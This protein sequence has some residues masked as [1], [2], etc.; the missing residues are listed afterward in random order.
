MKPVSIPLYS[1]SSVLRFEGKQSRKAVL[2]S[3]DF[4]D[5]LIRWTEYGKQADELAFKRTRKRLKKLYPQSVIVINTGRALP[6]V[7]SLAHF[8]KH[9]PVDVLALNN[10][11]E[12]YLN[13][14]RKR[15]DRWIHG[16]KASKQHRPWKQGIVNQTNWHG[17][18]VKKTVWKTLKEHGFKLHASFQEGAKVYRTTT[19]HG[20]QVDARRDYEPAFALTTYTPTLSDRV[21]QLSRELAEKIK[22]AL[23]YRGILAHYYPFHFRKQ[24][25]KNE[26]FFYGGHCFTPEGV[27]KGAVV[28]YL[29]KKLP[30]IKAVITG[31]DYYND[32]E[33]LRSPAYIN[34]HG[35]QVPNYA[36]ISGESSGLI[37]L[38]THGQ[39]EVAAKGDIGSAL[40]RQF[41]KARQL[42][43]QAN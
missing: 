5:T 40:Q 13:K 10:G 19:P 35:N 15:A 36:V 31:G 39:V 9:I 4:D 25:T 22:Q 30:H 33:M 14:Q 11:Q 21:H 1:S 26:T 8:F 18:Q 6:S 38:V 16:L 24:P 3:L 20:E 41:D 28:D 17:N 2:I 32:L 42:I 27:H 7:Q 29:V 12:L 43:S 37:P 34:G 23:R